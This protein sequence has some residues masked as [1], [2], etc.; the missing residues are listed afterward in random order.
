MGW[1]MYFEELELYIQLPDFHSLNRDEDI[2][3]CHTGN[4]IRIAGIQGL[5]T[6]PRVNTYHRET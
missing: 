1:I 5:I 6:F 2:A 4:M 3:P